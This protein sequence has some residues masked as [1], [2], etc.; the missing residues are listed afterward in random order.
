MTLGLDRPER[1]LS[2]PKVRPTAPAEVAQVIEPP[3]P[4]LEPAQSAEPVFPRNLPELAPFYVALDALANDQRERP[5]RI[6][7]WG[8][9]HTA[10]DFLTHP[11]R[12]HL[13]AQSKP[14]GPGFIRLGLSGYR[15]GAV[16]LKSDGRWRKAPIL[17][18]QRT[19]VLDGRIWTR[20]DSHTPGCRGAR[21]CRTA[22]ANGCA[23][24][25]DALLSIAERCST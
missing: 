5:V 6:L 21:D 12:E 10:A 4:D 1:E 24:A 20:R 13:N 17:P 9:S 16:R 3:T 15:H 8:D 23:H 11:I 18:A 19:R 25:L 14:G 7:W 22:R 2:R